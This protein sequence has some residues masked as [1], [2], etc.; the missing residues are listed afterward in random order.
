LKGVWAL[1]AV[2][3]VASAYLAWGATVG[4]GVV[5]CGT[6]SDCGKVLQSRWAWWLGLPVSLA[7]LLAYLGLLGATVLLHRS[8]AE[9]DGERAAWTAIIPLAIVIL[10]AAAWFIGL[11]AFVLHA[12]CKVC[13][14]THACAVAA[15]AWCLARIPW[16]RDA[17]ISLWGGS[18]GRRGVSLGMLASLAVAG[19]AG[20]AVLV[21]GQLAIQPKR[22]VVKQLP[23]AAVGPAPAS[24][25]RIQ[26][27]VGSP[28]ARPPSPNARLIAPRLLSLYDGEYLLR[29]DAAPILGSPDC[30]NVIVHLVDYTCFH[31]RS[32]HPILVETQR[33]LS[34][35]LAIVTL[36]LSMSTNCNPLIP[37]SIPSHPGSCDFIRI[38]LAVWRANPDAFLKFED[39]I[40]TPQDPPSV[41]RT[42]EFAV[43]LV[44]AAALEKALADPW[45]AEQMNLHSQIHHKNYAALQSRGMPQ[46]ILGNAISI[47]PLNSVDHLLVLLDKYLGLRAGPRP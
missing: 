46:I 42:R 30:T 44:G 26:A 22:N 14:A 15:A 40:F 31:C 39:W 19:L 29:L 28:P 23:P 11:Q 41:D 9:P 10:G 33:R 20:V 16:V 6:G 25:A 7:A 34:N 5:G 12:Y 13:L 38:S 45:I 3:V 18:S 27:A 47:G 21:G 24:N 36:P 1:L 17:S 32:L 4:G 8:R 37:A 43:E 2:A 35:R